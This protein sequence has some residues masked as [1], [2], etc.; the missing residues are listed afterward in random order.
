MDLAVPFYPHMECP[1]FMLPRLYPL[2]SRRRRLTSS[3]C[4]SGGAKNPNNG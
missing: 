4:S 2:Y 3:R 1:T